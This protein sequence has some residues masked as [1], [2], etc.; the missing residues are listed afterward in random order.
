MTTDEGALLK[1][2]C[3]RVIAD[4]SLAPKIEKK[5]GKILM[6]HC[7]RGALLVAQAMGCNEFDGEALTADQMIALMEDNASGKWKK[8]T[9]SDA[10]IHALSGGLGFAAKTSSELGAAHG[11]IATIYPVGMQKSSSW[12]R[13]V[14][15]VA[16]VGKENAEEKV[17]QVFPVAKGEPAY[18]VWTKNA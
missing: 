5:T 8:A 1:E 18:F 2:A 12:K 14:P 6:T 10:T 13:D 16:N 11:H 15:M 4:P 7:N 3:D 9:G 17:S